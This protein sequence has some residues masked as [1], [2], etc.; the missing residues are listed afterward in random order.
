[1]ANKALAHV[2]DVYS[3]QGTG[4]VNTGLVSA[5]Y[6][7]LNED[8]VFVSSGNIQTFWSHS[9]N[10]QSLHDDVANAIRIQTSDLS[11]VVVF[12]DTPGHF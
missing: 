8:S 1:M 4:I 2:V 6:V 9:V 10:V 7:V 11:L 5:K 3:G 12:T